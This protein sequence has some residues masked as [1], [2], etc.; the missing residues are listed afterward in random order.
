M[1]ELSLS[2]H[3]SPFSF[4][5]KAQE[6]CTFWGSDLPLS[7]I[8]SPHDFQLSGV[9]QSWR[10]K[11]CNFPEQFGF[12]SKTQRRRRCFSS[13]FSS[14]TS[15]LEMVL[16]HLLSHSQVQIIPTHI[17]KFS[18][19]QHPHLSGPF[20]TPG[21]SYISLPPIDHLTSVLTRGSVHSGF[22]Q[23]QE[24]HLPLVPVSCKAVHLP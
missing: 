4:R 18:S 1:E 10:L 24:W 3:S 7:F 19:Y 12:P 17:P 23:L 8:S 2:L 22:L 14:P 16:S 9:L 13:P 21:N 20:I 5:D 11:T 15:L 6:P